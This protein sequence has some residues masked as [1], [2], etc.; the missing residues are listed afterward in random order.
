ML[1]L[2]ILEIFFVITTVISLVFN[3]IQW[4]E[5]KAAKEPLSN[6]LV[7]TFNEIKSRANYV[8]FAYGALFNPNNPHKDVQT[9]RWEFGHFLQSELN[10]LEGPQEQLVSVLV[11]LRPEDKTGSMAFRARDYGLTEDDKEIRRMNFEKYKASMSPQPTPSELSN[12][13]RDG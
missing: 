7:G 9:I 5:G 6:A 10:T 2:S 12:T 4:R 3:I 11:S 8:H 1:T 13:E